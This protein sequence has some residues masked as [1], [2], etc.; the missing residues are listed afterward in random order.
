MELWQGYA[1][2]R[3][4]WLLIVSMIVIATSVAGAITALHQP[5]YRATTTVNTGLGQHADYYATGVQLA[6]L[7]AVL[8]SRYLL[9]QLDQNVHLNK[10]QSEIAKAISANRINDS[11]VLRIDVL[12]PDASKAQQAANTLADLFI[13][14]ES[15]QVKLQAQRDSLLLQ[16]QADL[17]RS[18]LD[19][20]LADIPV[21]Q[22][23]TDPSVLAANEE[24]IAAR[25]NYNELFGKLQNA[26]ATANNS[27]SGNNIT[28]IDRA[29]VPS[30]PESSKRLRTLVFGMLLG[31]LLGITLAIGAE[32]LNPI[33]RLR[34]TLEN[35]VRAPILA[36]I[37]WERHLRRRFY[38]TLDEMKNARR[39]AF[40]LLRS[41]V[42]LV[43]PAIAPQ[44]SD[45]D[46]DHRSP[47]AILVVAERSGSGGTSVVA[48]LGNT[49]ARAGLRV[50]LVDTNLAD[51]SL[52]RHVDM[53]Q[54][55][56]VNRWLGDPD[57]PIEGLLERSETSDLSFLSATRGD[58]DVRDR[59]ARGDLRQLI[60]RLK[61]EYD[62]IILDS[63]AIDRASDARMLGEAVDGVIL[64]LRPQGGKL[65]ERASEAVGFIGDNLIGV[66]LN[67]VKTE[68]GAI[69]RPSVR[70][71]SGDNI[72][73]LE[74][75]RAFAIGGRRNKREGTS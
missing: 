37:P 44:G 74:E 18:R 54:S 58:L 17:A 30:Q 12:W 5:V 59:L 70:P 32:Y 10:P 25:Q 1:I 28:V 29:A 6:D 73:P 7:Q 15:G 68:I 24:L 22:S 27:A 4:R 39:E 45:R 57:L 33:P 13:D 61:E 23:P 38:P 71:P 26:I 50:L 41:N 47:M 56:A 64:V 20:A 63:P 40:R 51:P 46:H 55:D 31:A 43:R 66:V 67:G 34:D 35:R 21:S 8:V 65:D 19:R 14:Y 48:G 42:T 72:L 53:P 36:A 2:L 69:G 49:F 9:T 11:A 60:G 62:V 52:H 16:Q 3:R 75:P